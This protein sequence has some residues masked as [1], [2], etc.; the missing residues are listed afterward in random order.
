MPRRSAQ[1][2]RRRRA[3]KEKLASRRRKRKREREDDSFPS[4]SLKIS[5]RKT[6]SVS[7]GTARKQP[8]EK[9]K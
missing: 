1:E 4:G 8:T 6:G 9:D 2:E 3:G 7:R 5:K